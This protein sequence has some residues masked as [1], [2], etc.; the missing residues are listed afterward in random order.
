MPESGLFAVQNLHVY[1]RMLP[2]ATYYSL[3]YSKNN[4]VAVRWK[5]SAVTVL[6]NESGE[7]KVHN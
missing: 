7:V 3:T 6:L 1:K 4:I 2:K 5:D